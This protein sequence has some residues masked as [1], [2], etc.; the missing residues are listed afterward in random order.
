M[1]VTSIQYQDCLFLTILR[2][3][4]LEKLEH[5]TGCAIGGEVSADVV[6]KGAG[7]R[8][9]FNRDAVPA[10]YY[11]V[12]VDVNA[13]SLFDARGAEFTSAALPSFR[14]TRAANAGTNR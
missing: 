8:A 7:Q 2:S 9:D 1:A 14:F 5:Q 6:V 3:H 4:V 11:V 12:G 13:E 10:V